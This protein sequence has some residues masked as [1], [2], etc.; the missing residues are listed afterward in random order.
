VAEARRRTGAGRL[1]MQSLF[2]LAAKHG[3]SRVEW[4][5]DHVNAEAQQFYDT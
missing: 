5:T 4:M 3:C 2:D 1:L